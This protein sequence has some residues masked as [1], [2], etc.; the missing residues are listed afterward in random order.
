MLDVMIRDASDNRQS[1]DDVMRQLYQSTYKARPR[2]HRRATGGARCRRRRGA[3]ASTTSPGNTWTGGS[4]IHGT[5]CC[6]WRASA[7]SQDTI[8]EP[9]LGIATSAGLGRQVVVTEVQPGGAAEEA[10][11]KTGD[12]LVALGDI[13]VKDPTFGPKF[14]ERFGKEDGQPLPI[15]CAATARP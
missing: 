12:V 1:L 2:L 14:R 9:R 10:G 11:V 8:R 6:R 13:P 7:W 3:R 4:R 5:R 15:R